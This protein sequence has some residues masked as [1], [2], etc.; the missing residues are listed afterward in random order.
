MKGGL[1]HG[2]CR[3]APSATATLPPPP[4]KGNHPGGAGLLAGSDQPGGLQMGKRRLLPGYPASTRFGHLFRRHCRPAAGLRGTKGGRAGSHASQA[5]PCLFE[6]PPPGGGVRRRLSAGRRLHDGVCRKMGPVPWNARPSPIPGK[7]APGAAPS[8]PSRRGPPSTP[9]ERSCSPTAAF[10]SLSAA[11]GCEKSRPCC[12][13]CAKRTFYRYC[14][15][16]TR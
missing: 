16:C 3:T 15:R 4:G 14:S 2:R 7:K 8:A 10:S 5:A 12:K 9:E 6:R 11:R 1:R 13:L